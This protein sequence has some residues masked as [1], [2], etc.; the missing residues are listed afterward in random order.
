M[1]FYASDP[2]EIGGL[3]MIVASGGCGVTV[4]VLQLFWNAAFFYTEIG[5]IIARQWS[6]TLYFKDR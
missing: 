5:I 3:R 4:R 2:N 1:G 6:Q